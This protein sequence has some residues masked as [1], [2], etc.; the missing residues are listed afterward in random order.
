MASHGIHL[1]SCW[2]AQPHF[3]QPTRSTQD[4]DSTNKKWQPLNGMA[5]SRLG[6]GFNL[7]PQISVD[8]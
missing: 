8:A 2:K 5:A 1:C 7:S 4:I 6:L 3:V